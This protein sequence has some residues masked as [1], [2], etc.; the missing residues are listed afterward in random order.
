MTGPTPDDRET[1]EFRLALLASLA[2]AVAEQIKDDKARLAEVM[3]VGDTAHPTVPD[4]TPRPAVAATITYKHGSSA[5]TFLDQD[6]KPSVT[7]GPVFDWVAKHHP[8]EIEVI[9]R[10]RPEY[11]KGFVNA[12][13]VA[14]APHG[15]VDVDGAAVTSS[16]ATVQVKP[17]KENRE[18]LFAS[19]RSVTLHELLSV[20]HD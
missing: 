14:V 8:E 5:L 13:G 10:V 2:Q 16:P 7:R 1:V 6:P 18:H 19:M 4:G 3:R 15:E 11:L 20:S 17:E 9:E 12:N